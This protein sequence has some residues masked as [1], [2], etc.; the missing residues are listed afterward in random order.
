MPHTDTFDLGA[1]NLEREM[2]AIANGEA[3]SGGASGRH[4]MLFD[5]RQAKVT[6]KMRDAV[7]LAFRSSTFL[8]AAAALGGGRTHRARKPWGDF[9]LN[10]AFKRARKKAG[11]N[12]WTFRDLRHFFLTELFRNGASARAIQMLAGRADLATTQLYADL[13]ANDLR[14]AIERIDGEGR[15]ASRG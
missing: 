9:G 8:G 5:G 12:G 11:L 15:E 13:D 7:R 6:E 3:P 1:E 4:Q 10:Q 14:S 2:A